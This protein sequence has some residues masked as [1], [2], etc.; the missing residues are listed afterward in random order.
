MYL[1]IVFITLCMR[2][3][4]CSIY[5]INNTNGPTQKEEDTE[6]NGEDRFVLILLTV[7]SISIFICGVLTMNILWMNMS[8]REYLP[9]LKH[10]GYRQ[11]INQSEEEEDNN[12]L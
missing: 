6:K 5:I 4:Q 8:T 9:R 11:Q 12:D 1:L 7:L 10:Q 3:Y 2:Y